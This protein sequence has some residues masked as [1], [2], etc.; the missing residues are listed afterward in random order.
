MNFFYC[1]LI[2]A[3]HAR[4]PSWQC[5]CDYCNEQSVNH[6]CGARFRFITCLQK[7]GSKTGCVTQPEFNL[8]SFSVCEIAGKILTKVICP[9]PTFGE[10]PTGNS[11]QCTILEFEE[12]A[13]MLCDLFLDCQSIT[14]HG[15]QRGD[16][17]TV[18]HR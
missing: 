5:L 6:R 10:D 9:S 15:D 7:F 4:L 1:Q 3:R 2:S 17:S 16:Y 18:V 12:N 8:K 14:G 13:R 11:N